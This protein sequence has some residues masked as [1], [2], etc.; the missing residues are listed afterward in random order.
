MVVIQ[1]G[2]KGLFVYVV[3]ED[4][5]VIV[6]LVKI[7]L[8]QD[9]QIVI[10]DGIVV[11]EIVVIDGIDCLCE[12][13]KV[14]VVVCG[15]VDDLVNKLIIENLEC[16]YGKCGQGGQGGEVGQGGQGG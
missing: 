1:C 5:I 14:E 9:D 3:K 16:C 6:C 12:G 15:G 4:N 11:G 13:V 8:V 2:L 10:I 7:G